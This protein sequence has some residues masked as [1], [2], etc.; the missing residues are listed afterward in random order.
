MNENL[1][2]PEGDASTAELSPCGVYRYTLT[3]EWE[4]GQCVVW[5]M[6]NP[7]TANATE[8]DPTIRKC[9][10]F[11]KRWGYGRM[12]VVNLFAVR[13]T[14]PKAV[15]RMSMADAEGPMNGYWIIEAAKE[16]REVIC[17]WGCAQHLP[18][19]AERIGNVVALIRKHAPDTPLTC[20]GR[21]QDQHPRHPLMLAYATERQA[22]GWGV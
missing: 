2:D 9:V 1:F 18:R 21:R 5:L 13:S 6:F 22:F 11:S 3:R 19:I 20:L 14:D 10:G 17:A 4:D 8:D 7:S 15:A 16:G 12:V